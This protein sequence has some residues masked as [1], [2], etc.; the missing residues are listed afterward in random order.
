MKNLNFENLKND[1]RTFIL[2]ENDSY[3]HSYSEF[4]N[5]FKNIDWIEKHHLVIAIHFVYGWMPTII[6]LNTK[7]LYEVLKELSFTAIV[8]NKS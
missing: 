4:I 3:I 6:Q 1:V 5:Y 7:N 2:T 8:T